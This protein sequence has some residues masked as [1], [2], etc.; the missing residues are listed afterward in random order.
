MW[1]VFRLVNTLAGD[2]NL[3]MDD[4][5]VLVNVGKSKNLEMAS[6]AKLWEEKFRR[7]LEGR[8]RVEVMLRG[9][10]DEVE[11]LSE[12]LKIAAIDVAEA[13]RDQMIEDEEGDEVEGDEFF[14]GSNEGE[15]GFV[16]SRDGTFRER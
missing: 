14:G 7:E 16:V 6:D 1:R 13:A 2:S 11:T 10:K 4:L 9:Y 5:R 3:K 15:G 8:K 12:A